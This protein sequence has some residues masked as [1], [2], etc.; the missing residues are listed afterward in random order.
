MQ[1]Q[2]RSLPRW[3]QYA[4]GISLLAVALTAGGLSLAMNISSGLALSAAI[5]IAFAL[6]DIGK[7][8]LPVVCQA[9]GWTRHLRAAYL[10]ASLVSGL[11][12]ICFLADRFGA[13]IAAKE[14]ATALS[15]HA[16][17]QIA[18]LRHSLASIRDMAADE[19]KRGGCGAKCQS[20][21]S[22]ASEL[23][24]KLSVALAK[25]ET[26]PAGQF[27]GKARLF[28]AALGTDSSDAAHG[29][30]I[31]LIIS[32]LLVMELFAHCS[33]AAAAMIASAMHSS[34]ATQIAQAAKADANPRTAIKPKTV[35]NKHYWLA[36]LQRTHPDIASRVETGELSCYRGC[37]EAGIRKPAASSSQWAKL[38][39]YTQHLRKNIV[40]SEIASVG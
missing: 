10:I 8:L 4:S 20:L 9:I 16:D 40:R 38:E 27:D 33:G 37:V 34:P 12:A 39:T 21:N 24:S 14:N 32:A 11:C 13:D 31:I 26:A 28:A 6:S 1:Q 22:Q 2:S 29:T 3:A 36:R 18:D 7:M 35:A 19:A 17:Q 25:R 5:A 23:E 30:A 15:V